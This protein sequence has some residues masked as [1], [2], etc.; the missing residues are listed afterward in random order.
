MC[1]VALLSPAIILHHLP[2]LEQTLSSRGARSPAPSPEGTFLEFAK[3]VRSAT[4]ETTG[5]LEPSKPAEYG[6]LA[7]P[8]LGHALHYVARRA[9]RALSRPPG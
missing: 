2:G 1:I 4:P 3:Q 8:S 9:T 6:I 7:D 5:F